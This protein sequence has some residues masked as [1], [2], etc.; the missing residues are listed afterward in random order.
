[1]SGISANPTTWR[2]YQ[3]LGFVY[4]RRNDY[5]KAS[6]VYAAGAR[7]PGAPPW[8]AAISARMKAEGGSHDAAREMYRHQYDSSTDEA[9]KDMVIKQLMRLDSLDQREA[10]R[11]ILEAYKARNQRCVSSWRDISEALRAQR[12]QLDSTG[13]PLDPSATPYRLIATDCDVD[14]EKG[15]KVPR[16]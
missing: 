7:L 1:D 10:I 5:H 13:A 12:F 3:H 16:R 8:M 14:L 6:E 11:R 2:L 9:V 4:W 15:S